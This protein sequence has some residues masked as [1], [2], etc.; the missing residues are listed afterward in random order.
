[1]QIEVFKAPLIDSQHIEIIKKKQ[2]VYIINN[3]QT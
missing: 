2:K 3:Y 1:M